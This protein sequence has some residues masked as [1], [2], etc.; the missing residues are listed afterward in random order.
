M[1][2]AQRRAL[3]ELWPRYGLSCEGT[4]F[5]F[6][7]IF[8]NENPVYLEIGFGMGGSLAQMAASHPD[9]NYLGIEVHRPGVGTLLNRIHDG[10]LANLRVMNSDAVDIITDCIGPGSLTGVLIFFP[11]PWMKKRHHKRR[12]VQAPLITALRERLQTGGILHLATDWEDYAQHM[13]AVMQQIE[14]MRNIAGDG[15][16]AERPAYRP[17]TKYEARGERL[18]HAVRDLIFERG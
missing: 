6:A 1:S 8:G 17:L 5:D 11:D 18:G 14:G 13:L 12:L 4:V 2:P 10:Q 3:T 7:G 16:Y 15:L 9:Y